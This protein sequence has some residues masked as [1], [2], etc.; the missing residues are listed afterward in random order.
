[1]KQILLFDDPAIRGSLLPF[2]FTRPVADIRVGIM[3]I[4]EKWEKYSGVE[5]SF[6]TQDYLQ[7]KFPRNSGISLAVNGSWLPEEGSIEILKSLKEDEVLVSGK[8][9]LATYIG[10]TEKNL[11]SA[12]EKKQIQLEMEPVL[13]QK[14][15]QIFQFNAAEIRKD[16]N[17]LTKG[18]VSQAITDP[19][20]MVY[21]KENI[22]VEE[23]AKIKA[24]VLNAEGGPIYIGKNTEI[25]EGSLIRG[26]FALCEGSTINM[27]AKLRGD[28]TVGP[29]S[30]VG[31]EVS[32]SVIFGYSNKGHEGFLGNSVVGEWCN[33]GA[34]TNT[35]NLKNNYA[36]V[37][38]WDYTKGGFAN[39][40]LQFCG[41]M[42]GDHSK[43]GINTM[44]NT[45]TVVGVGANIF[46]D[47]FP[48]NFIP[49]FSWGGAA[50]FSTFTLPK[51][52][53][54]AKAVYGRRGKEFTSEEKEILEKVFELTKSYRIWEKTT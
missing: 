31:G 4:S 13:L 47:G 14:T 5:V 30:K 48:R 33:L 1:M 32:N 42:M 15:W 9:I 10:E 27:G 28:T 8:T 38:L 26:P 41:L 11:G 24:A 6:L 29:Y 34:D 39:T 7:K 36:P 20:T 3:K 53:E 21:G 18:R 12:L 23:S 19:H 51:F 35:S 43:C 37:K 44:F 45:G 50:G 54:T 22:F 17:L 2:T 40:G 16:F 52:E 46:G 49:S 25:Q